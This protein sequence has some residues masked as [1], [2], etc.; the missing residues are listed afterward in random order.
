[1]RKIISILVFIGLS[2]VTRAAQVQSWNDT[3]IF[4]NPIF[5]PASSLTNIFTPSDNG[6]LSTGSG[7]IWTWDTNYMGAEDLNH[8]FVPNYLGAMTRTVRGNGTTINPTDTYVPRRID[9]WTFGDSWWYY[10]PN[11]MATD[12]NIFF[13][14]GVTNVLQRAGRSLRYTNSGITSV[15]IEVQNGSGANTAMTVNNGLGSL[16]TTE[17]QLA[18]SA[19]GAQ[20]NLGFSSLWPNSVAYTL[21]RSTTPWAGLHLNAFNDGLSTNDVRSFTS[22]SAADQAWV[23]DLISLTNNTPGTAFGLIVKT[24]SV[25]SFRWYP[26]GVLEFGS[27]AGTNQLY[28]VG[29]DLYWNGAKINP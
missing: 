17:T 29:N 19:V 24:N 10:L 7:S 6:V 20:I 13:G 16:Q 23:T 21:G 14:P 9:A 25:Q 12:T 8:V 5:N 1:M 27:T 18:L 11:G 2:L 26:S 15:N 4:K 28:P 3:N 22:W